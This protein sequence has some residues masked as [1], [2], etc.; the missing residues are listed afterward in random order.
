MVEEEGVCDAGSTTR[1]RGGLEDWRSGSS[2]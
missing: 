1:R 2:K